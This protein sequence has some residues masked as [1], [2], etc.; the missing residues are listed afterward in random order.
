MG[1]HP[2]FESDFDCLTGFK[3]CHQR[4]RLLRRLLPEF[5][6]EWELILKSELSDY[7]MSENQP[8][9]MFLPNPPRPPKISHFVP[10]TRTKP[11]LQF[12]TIGSTCSAKII[13]PLRKFRLI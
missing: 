1:T 13:N 3:R 4:R 6:V 11:E 2:I 9:S 10:L 12:Q 5:W 8:F 7:L